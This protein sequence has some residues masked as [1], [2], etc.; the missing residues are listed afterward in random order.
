[1][2]VSTGIV[3]LSSTRAVVNI[4]LANGGRM[5]SF[6]VDG[7]EL[8]H[9]ESTE[10]D[11]MSWGCYP[12]APF[13]GRVRDGVLTHD[14]HAH[15]LRINMAP[16]SIHGSV[17]DREWE[18]EGGN[19]FVCDLGPEWPWRGHAVQVIDVGEQALTL[20]LE[21]HSHGDSV[22]A[23]IGWHPWFRTRL[24][25]GEQLFLEAPVGRQVLRDAT[26]MPSGEWAAPLPRPWDDCFTDVDWPITLD[27]AGR[28]RLSITSDCSYVVIYD[29]RAH[30]WC[31][32]P[33]S[34]PPDAVNGAAD[35]VT[36]DEPLIATTT[37]TW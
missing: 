33:Q 19:R 2:R 35:L 27:W 22:P 31:V 34:A 28:R 14:G 24:R 17:F 37:W 32:E 6:T 18:H 23:S 10:D 1:L 9:T 26:G 4:D 3:T 36:S 20:R 8:L 12:M 25:S 21:V 5:A 29:E 16:H 15:H 7:D 30:A 13:A 11:P